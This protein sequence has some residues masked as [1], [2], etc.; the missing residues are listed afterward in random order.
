VQKNFEHSREKLE[1]R[2]LVC[3]K[4]LALDLNSI[5]MI[6][7]DLK[8]NAP[9]ED[10]VDAIDIAAHI[11]RSR[12]KLEQRTLVCFKDRFKICH[13][14]SWNFDSFKFKE[15]WIGRNITFGS[16]RHRF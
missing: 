4:D 8:P 2:T 5:S 3:F 10:Q 11:E 13:K 15:A 1:Q 7:K 16:K 14:F 6:M 12:E 9:V